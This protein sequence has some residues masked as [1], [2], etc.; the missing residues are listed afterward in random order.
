MYIRGEFFSRIYHHNSLE[1]RY[2]HQIPCTLSLMISYEASVVLESK[3]KHYK[4]VFPSK[5]NFT[6]LIYSSGSGS[7]TN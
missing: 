2:V 6:A 5:Q 3:I 7:A 1:L 4:S